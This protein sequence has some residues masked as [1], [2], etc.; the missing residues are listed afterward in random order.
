MKKFGSH[1][2]EFHEI[3]YFSIFLKY[4]EETQVLLKWDKNE[5]Y[6]M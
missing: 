3:L 4:V 1:W 6:F 2:T 5:G